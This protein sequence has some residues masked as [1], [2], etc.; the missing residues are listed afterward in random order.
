MEA[1]GSLDPDDRERRINEVIADYIR[2]RDNGEEPDEADLL[3]RHPD[4]E[5]ELLKFFSSSDFLGWVVASSVPVLPDRRAQ[6]GPYRLLRVIGKGGMGVVYEAEDTRS[7]QHVALKILPTCRLPDPDEVERFRRGFEVVAGLRHPN[8][9][10]PLEFGDHAGIPYF[11][12]PLI[13]GPNL[14]AVVRSLCHARTPPPTTPSAGRNAEFVVSLEESPGSRETLSADGTRWRAVAL[15]GLQAARALAHAHEREIL[16]RDVKPS[17]LLLDERGHVYLTDFGLA[18]SGDHPDLTETGDLVGTLRYMAPER[19]NRFCDRRS[20]LYSLGLTLYELL[21]LRPAFDDPDRSRLLRAMLEQAPARPRSLVRDIPHDLETI[22]LRLIEKEPGHRYLFA[23]DLATDLQRYLD[24]R[25]IVA[26]RSSPARRLWSWVRRHKAR[27]TALVLAVVAMIAG[28]VATL[29][30]ERMRA[31]MA[32]FQENLAQAERDTALLAAREAR[33]QSL[34]IQIQ[35]SRT[36]LQ[37]SG[38]RE[39][40]WGSIL[41]ANAISPGRPVLRDQAVATLSGLDALPL[42]LKDATGASSLAFDST[43]Q[44]LLLGGLGPGDGQ[45]PRSKFLDLITG[46]VQMLEGA[47]PGPV[48]FLSDGTQLQFSAEGPKTLRLRNLTL[49]TYR[50]HF[51]V[52]EPKPPPSTAPANDK[53]LVTALAPDGTLVAAA[54]GDAVHVW[55]GLTGRLLVSVP[56]KIGALAFSNDGSVFAAGDETGH[57]RVWSMPDGALIAEFPQGHAPITALAIVR[58]P[59]RDPDGRQ[60][61]LVAACDLAAR[62]VVYDLTDKAVA[63]VWTGKETEVQA[64]VFSPDAT[65]LAEVGLDTTFWDVALGHPILRLRHSHQRALAFSRDGRRV[66]IACP[67]WFGPGRVAVWELEP[68]QGVVTLRGL[69]S[70][71]S[72]IA[73]SR[74]GSVAAALCSGWKAAAWDLPSGRLRLVVD[75]PIGLSFDNAAIAVSPDGKLLAL[76]AGRQAHL[77]DLSSAR[78]FQTWDL[79]PGLVDQLGFPSADRLL[80]FRAEP[81]TGTSPPRVGLIRDLLSSDPLTPLGRTPP[82]SPRVLVAAASYDGRFFAVEGFHDVSPGPRRSYRVYDGTTGQELWARASEARTH[83]GHLVIDPSGVVVAI[84]DQEPSYTATVHDIATGRTREVWSVMPDCLSPG[85][86]LRVTLESSSSDDS[87]PV[88]TLRRGRDE[89]LARF[90]I[91]KGATHHSSTFSPD[92]GRLAFGHADGTVTVC[93]LEEVRRRLAGV[94]LGW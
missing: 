25:P 37:R 20:D 23:E 75:A 61:R 32:K 82:F 2:A 1:G 73:F 85:A 87:L 92:G 60:G 28:V 40:A 39:L 74:D 27:S 22:V 83:N 52:P 3:K 6:F 90:A 13:E 86:S 59:H 88:P 64:L 47:G 29:S 7:F 21:T 10:S 72:R 9:L 62:V 53:P 66:A 45:D 54:D 4:L 5:Q 84:S 51:D 91:D 14:R 80:S 11:T 34:V 77:W 67:P 12:M 8:I 65:V 46:E 38:W 19:F 70:P 78:R 33:Y 69:D 76:S 94:G 30:Y 57:V 81:P 58:D 43:G 18:R 56:G 17:N 50:A 79:P 89:V 63:T 48:A 16:H 24:G 15:I 71:V 41:A 68:G 93:D 55:N 35:Q 36:S 44:K 31:N 42:L 26:R 49:G